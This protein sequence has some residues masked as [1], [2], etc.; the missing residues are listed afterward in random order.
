MTD[1]IQVI[2]RNLENTDFIKSKMLSIIGGTI[3]LSATQ[4]EKTN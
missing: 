4:K 2:L 3:I 1:P